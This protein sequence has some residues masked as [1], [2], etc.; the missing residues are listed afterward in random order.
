M[1]TP[2]FG[3]ISNADIDAL[4]DLITIPT[5]GAVALVVQFVVGTADLTDFLVQG[6]CHPSAGWST[7]ATATGDFTT[8]VFPIQKASGDLNA[9][10]SG[11]TV[12]F[13]IMDCA[14]MHEVLLR[15]AGTSSTITG[16]W[17]AR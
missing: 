5:R 13:L 12:H 6:R 9:A 4:E 2:T 14:G 11:A 16:Y 1:T 7:L 8:P 3:P 17:G 15:A 10:A